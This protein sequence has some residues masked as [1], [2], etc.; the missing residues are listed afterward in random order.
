MGCPEIAEPLLNTLH[1]HVPDHFAGVRLA[2]FVAE[3]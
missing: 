3:A 1:H 2:Q